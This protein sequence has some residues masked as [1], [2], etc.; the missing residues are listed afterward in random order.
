[1]VI[2][3][4]M[5]RNPSGHGGLAKLNGATELQSPGLILTHLNCR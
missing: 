2:S 5:A 1:M 4:C 3:T